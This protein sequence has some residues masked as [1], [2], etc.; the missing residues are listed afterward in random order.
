VEVDPTTGRLE[1]RY[2]VIIEHGEQ[3]FSAYVPIEQV[4]YQPD[5]RSKRRSAI[6]K[7]PSNFILRGCAKTGYRFRDP[8]PWRSQKSRGQFRCVAAA[9][10]G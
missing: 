3:N 7:K 9:E 8:R 2:P 10:N 4:A 1:M 6:S 5:R